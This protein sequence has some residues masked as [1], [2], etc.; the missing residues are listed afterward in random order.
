MSSEKAGGAFQAGFVAKGA[1]L[2]ILCFQCSYTSFAG[3]SVSVAGT[4][5]FEAA[6]AATVD[7]QGN[8]NVDLNP[9]TL[10]CYSND[11]YAKCFPLHVTVK[12]YFLRQK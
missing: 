4:Q 3:A 11:H 12:L 10:I 6:F 5:G 8:W 1:S 2:L 7:V 9:G